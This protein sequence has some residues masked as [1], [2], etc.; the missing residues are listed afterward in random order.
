MATSASASPATWARVI[1]SLRTAL[2]RITVT[3]GARPTNGTTMAAFA[4]TPM[5]AMNAILPVPPRTPVTKAYAPP[6]GKETPV[7][8]FFENSIQTTGGRSPSENSTW[9][10]QGEIRSAIIL[11]CS[12]HA[13]HRKIVRSESH[14][15]A[16]TAAR[17]LGGVSVSAIASIELEFAEGPG[18]EAARS[19]RARCRSLSTRG[20]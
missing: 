16:G 12:P 1:F 2:A 3:N 14:S 10:I 19:P 7:R 4:P 13:P 6:F 8:K 20:H 11:D 5:D 9:F 18:L 17:D 15:H